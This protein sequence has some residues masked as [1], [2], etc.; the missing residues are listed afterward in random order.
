M[1]GEPYLREIEELVL[2]FNNRFEKVFC[3]S[4][5]R[6]DKNIIA[7]KTMTFSQSQSFDLGLSRFEFLKAWFTGKYTIIIYIRCYLKKI[8]RL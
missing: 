1:T 4:L 2:G 5:E 3:F 6:K 8:T 7:I